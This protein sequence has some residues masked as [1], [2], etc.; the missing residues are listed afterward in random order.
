MQKRILFFLLF[1]CLVTSPVWAKVS[2]PVPRHYVQDQANVIDP[3]VEHSLNGVLQELE[4]KT[5]AQYI[6]LTVKNMQGLSI[7]QFSIELAEQ[8]KLW[9]RGND[10][11]RLFV[12]STKERK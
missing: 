6:V 3:S 12:L 10:N 4:Q 2:M 1:I 9:Q 5:G 11:G 7:E 8:W